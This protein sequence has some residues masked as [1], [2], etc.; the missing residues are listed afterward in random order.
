MVLNIWVKHM[1]KKMK[2]LEKIVVTLLFIAMISVTSYINS[3]Q[4]KSIENNVNN[5]TISY[6]ISNIPKQKGE[7]YVEINNNIPKFTSDDMNL[8]EDY[9]STLQDGKARNGYDKN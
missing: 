3:K 2:K 9:Y 1:K 8:E 4:E 5:N 6:E 7:I